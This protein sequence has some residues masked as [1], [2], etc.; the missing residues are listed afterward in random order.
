[1]RRAVGLAVDF[2][3]T[4]MVGIVDMSPSLR[5]FSCNFEIELIDDLTQQEKWCSDCD[6]ANAW[7][8]DIRHMGY[9]VDSVRIE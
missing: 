3:S 8:K 2:L 6:S 1:M 4:Q 7:G 9:S 5:S